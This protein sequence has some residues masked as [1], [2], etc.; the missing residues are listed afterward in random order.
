[1]I[2]QTDYT[3]A[4]AGQYKAGMAL[5]GSEPELVEWELSDHFFGSIS[6]QT[7]KR[8]RIKIY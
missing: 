6:L 2:T 8:K 3:R 5:L 1:M 4:N 7:D